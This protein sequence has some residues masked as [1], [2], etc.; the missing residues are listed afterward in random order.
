MARSLVIVE[1]P[2]KAKTINKFLGRG[3]V[4]KASMGH[5]RDLP[6]KTLGVDEKSFAPTYT[7]L[8]E[9]KKITPQAEGQAARQVQ[10]AEAYKSQVVQLATG[11]ASRFSQ[12]AAAYERAPAITR[13][14]MYIE[15][16]EAVLRGSRKVIIDSKSGGNGNMFYLPLDKLIDRS[17]DAESGTI[18]VRPT[19]TVEPEPA[20]ADSR[21]RVER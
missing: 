20:P 19:V 1:S 15:S 17:R 3:F 9:K 11:D 13:E 5:V 18:T 14:R 8:P 21:G 6:K 7:A 4:V 16:I 2:A 10:D 12:V